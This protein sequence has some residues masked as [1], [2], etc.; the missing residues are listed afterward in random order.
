MTV[1]VFVDTNVLVYARDQ[2]EGDKHTSA[3]VWI[4]HLW[5]DRT[6][7]LSTQVLHEFYVTVTRK[8]HPGL[9]RAEARDEVRN[10]LAWRPVVLDH[11][12]LDSTFAFEDRF[13]LSF[14]DA[15]VVAAAAAA[16]CRHLLTEDLQAGQDFDGVLVVDPFQT[17][18]GAL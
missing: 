7:R 12:V 16:G 18:P 2:S 10:L 17:E 9:T 5:R 11:R 14:W 1:P 6:G 4:D 3:S 8:L 15:M 13:G